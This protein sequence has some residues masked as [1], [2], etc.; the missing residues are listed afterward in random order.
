VELTLVPIL[1]R[2]IVGG[3][4]V[5]ATIRIGDEA[6]PRCRV[7]CTLDLPPGRH[8]LEVELEGHT[9]KEVF[10]DVAARRSVTL[11]LELEA[12]MGT[13]VVTTDE[14]G[15][16]VEID[17]RPRGFTPAIVTL[18]VG[19]HRVR[20]S[21][22]GFRA[23]Q[24]VVQIQRDRQQR[25]DLTLTQAE[26]VIAASRVTESVEDAPS[27][28]TILPHQELRALAYPTIA[29]AIRGV[30]GIY[31][32][33]DR[34]YVG[35]GV[36]GLGR[37]GSYGNRLLIL[38]DGQPTNDNWIGAS[39]VGYDGRTDLADIERIEVIRGP[40]SVLY[41]TN[42]FSGVVNLVTRHR[43]VPQGAEVGVS[44][45]LDSVGRARARGDL[46]F[47][48][49]AGVWTSVAGAHGEGR[50]FFF[51]EFVTETPPEVA[52]HARGA[53]GFDAGTIQGRAWWKSVTTQW[54]YHTHSKRLPTGEYVTLLGDPRTRQTDRRAFVEARVEPQLSRELALLG[55]VHLNYYGFR[56]NYARDAVDE[57]VEIDTFSGQWLGV[58]GRAVL[59]PIDKLRL[60]A[61]GEVQSH[62]EVE[63]TGSTLPGGPGTPRELFLDDT[64]DA[65]RNFAVLAGYVLGDADIDE[66]IRISAGARL[67]YY[68]DTF[69]TSLNP[70]GAL[71]VQ[72]YEAG[73]SKLMVGKAFRAPSVYE[74][75]YNDGGFTQVASPDLEPEIIWSV[76]LEHQHRFSPTLTATGTV[77]S[78]YV[79]SLIDQRGN[80]T[81]AD[82]LFYV[83]SKTPFLAIGGELGVQRDWRQGWMLG[84]SYGYVNTRYLAS[85]SAGDLSSLARDPERRR[86][87]NAPV[88]LATVK[89]AVP[90]IARHVTAASRLTL[91][92][93]RYDRFEAVGD[94]A[95]RAT[96]A[97]VVWDVVLSGQEPRW[98]L[99]W[100]LGAYNAFDWRYEVPVST[101]FRQRTMP[102]S[103]R[104]FLAS[105]GLKF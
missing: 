65:A 22:R 72:P 61:G 41:G 6:L 70:R 49:D 95:Q 90:I 80:G 11:S 58:E 69:G 5:G 77:F 93:P 4:A 1:G 53:D 9:P 7:P 12:L 51:P 99:D 64:G 38:I 98:G 104:T 35:V 100:A 3:P 31:L 14:R 40:G 85:T 76:E 29:E 88:H 2:L 21:L 102:Q 15:A 82:P 56:G 62:Y 47:G 83:N 45:N 105:A 67:D 36:R 78:N 75:Y 94:A 26:E 34:S 16:L 17:G 28:V 71:I 37:L 50:D 48:R 39:Y 60:T 87:A 32:E 8:A 63:Q 54:F 24:H 10:V 96:E 25:I 33:D 59:T 103:G 84:A 23:I 55:R 20:V 42:A 46:R 89:A 92:G 52:G 86:V 18:P 68:P 43:D 79:S 73:N 66:R 13:L 74:L 81:E 97:A 30:R 101:E 57:G 44:T 27:S 19:E 91:E